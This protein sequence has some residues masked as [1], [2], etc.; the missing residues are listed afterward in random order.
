MLSLCLLSLHLHCKSMCCLHEL[1]HVVS[2]WVF[3]DQQRRCGPVSGLL[4][5]TGCWS[6]PEGSP[7]SCRRSRSFS[8]GCWSSTFSRWWPSPRCGL[9][10]KRYD[11]IFSPPPL[12]PVQWVSGVD[13]PMLCSC[14]AVSDEPGPG[15]AVVSGHALRSLQ[16]HG[17][18]PVHAVGVCHHCV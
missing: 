18:L 7:T 6:C 16:T 2:K 17:L 9:H 13:E 15:G 14:A 5:Q 1:M 3:F 10:W 8:G 11:L 12:L 4:W